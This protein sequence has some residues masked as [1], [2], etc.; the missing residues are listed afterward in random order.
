MKSNEFNLPTE[1]EVRAVYREGEEAVVEQFRRMNEMINHL[2][3]R[4]QALEN[5]MAKN[6]SNSSKPHP[7]MEL[8]Q[9]IS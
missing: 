3:G 6:S 9:N 7:V 4:I 5:Q 1:A 2:I 8:K